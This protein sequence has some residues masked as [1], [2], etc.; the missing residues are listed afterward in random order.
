MQLNQPGISDSGN[1]GEIWMKAYSLEVRRELIRLVHDDGFSGRQA[2]FRLGIAPSTAT[3]WIRNFHETGSAAPVQ[4]SGSRRSSIQG[5]HRVW[6]I[7]R[8]R[9]REFT[10]RGLVTEL[11]ERGVKVDFRS[12]WR[13]IHAENLR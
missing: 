1:I 13:F 10:Y 12:V 11:A 9:L 2:A 5:A 8:C 4:L 6:L 7:D 3:N